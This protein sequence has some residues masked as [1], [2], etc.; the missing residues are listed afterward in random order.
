MGSWERY[1]V[2]KSSILFGKIKKWFSDLKTVAFSGNYND[3]S[4]KPTIDSALSN[5]STNAVQNNVVYT[6]FEKK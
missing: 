2:E 1:D 6:E 3:L 4:D 5:T